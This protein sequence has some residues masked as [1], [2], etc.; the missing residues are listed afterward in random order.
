MVSSRFEISQR[1]FVCS[2]CIGF[3]LLCQ[4]C[5]LLASIYRWNVESYYRQSKW[6]NIYDDGIKLCWQI[7]QLGC[8]GSI[9]RQPFPFDISGLVHL[10]EFGVSD[11]AWSE[12]RSI[13]DNA[14]QIFIC[15][16]N[17][18][19]IIVIIISFH[20]LAQSIVAG[21]QIPLGLDYVQSKFGSIPHC[22]VTSW[23]QLLWCWPSFTIP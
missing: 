2:G 12:V 15:L 19:L 16:R 9:Y 23:L 14:P 13:V 20:A 1:V 6:A 18:I 3:A 11:D 4:G 8:P 10:H 21:L 17:P 5:I 7:W 22:Q